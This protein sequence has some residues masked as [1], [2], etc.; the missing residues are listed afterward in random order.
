LDLVHISGPPK[1]YFER[2]GVVILRQAR[3]AFNENFMKSTF[4]AIRWKEALWTIKAPGSIPQ[5][6][7]IPRGL[8][9]LLNENP[10]R[11]PRPLALGSFIIFAAW[12]ELRGNKKKAEKTTGS[13]LGMGL[14]V[15]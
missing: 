2:H 3:A 14:T 7:L 6:G 13:N 1:K 12:P 11:I 8:P 5:V 9:R 15:A 10:C 4:S